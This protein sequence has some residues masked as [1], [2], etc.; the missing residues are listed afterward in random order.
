[1]P[2][3][4]KED[5]RA[6]IR[7]LINDMTNAASAISLLYEANPELNNRPGYPACLPS[8]DEFVLELLAWRDA[9]NSSGSF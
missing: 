1:M 2:M 7:T 4:F 9:E 6:M 5:P 3:M 8:M